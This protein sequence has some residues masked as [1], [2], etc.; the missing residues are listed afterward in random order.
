[1][2]ASRLM[3]DVYKQYAKFVESVDDRSR[4]VNATVGVTDGKVL[5]IPEYHYCH[6]SVGYADIRK[7]K[8]VFSQY[9]KPAVQ[10][11]VIRLFY[12]WLLNYSPYRDA[13]V[14]KNPRRVFED[15]CIITKTDLPSNYIGGALIASRLPTER[16]S[17]QYNI[18]SAVI[19]WSDLV[20]HG[21]PPNMAFVMACTFRPI[22]VKN[23]INDKV[24]I[25]SIESIGFNIEYTG[26][27]PMQTQGYYTSPDDN[28]RDK[29][30]NAEIAYNNFFFDRRVGE[31]SYTMEERQTISY[32][33]Y[34]WIGKD[35]EVKLIG[36]NERFKDKLKQVDKPKND[37]P[38][39]PFANP[40]VKISES[41]FAYGPAIEVL[42]HEAKEIVKELV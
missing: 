20:K 24:F 34:L 3:R 18:P 23:N 12:E 29:K 7:P 4:T 22:T 37:K 6:A 13:F 14:T 39:N 33:S 11:E 15:K 8:A 9:Q 31:V 26:H 27:Y 40:K 21:V 10:E 36:I 35:K 38:L 28:Y 17:P 5:K 41:C 25:D 16:H 1:M 42:A 19:I 30:A 2:K 32:S